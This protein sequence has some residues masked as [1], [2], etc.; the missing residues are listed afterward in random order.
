MN[1]KGRFQNLERSLVRF[2]DGKSTL[3]SQTFNLGRSR[4]AS[5]LVV[6]DNIIAALT[7]QSCLKRMHCASEHA[8]NG[9]EAIRLVQANHYDL[10]LMDLGLPDINGIETTKAIRALNMPQA[11]NVP[12]IAL[13][14]HSKDNEHAQLSLSAGM[15]AVFTKPLPQSTLKSILEHFVFKKRE[16]DFSQRDLQRPTKVIDWKASLQ[17]LNNDENLL[18][19]LLE[20]INIDL[21]NSLKT[22]EKAYLRGDLDALRVE[23]HRVRGGICYLCLPQLDEALTHFHK[24]VKTQPTDSELLAQS[25][26][27]V[28]AAMVAYWTSYNSKT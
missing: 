28:K 27:R 14:G 17:H 23:L 7:L 13:T 5:I 16:N 9:Q 12:I 6:E 11:L 19:E 4:A 18:Q 8:L 21:K 25:Y 15:Q 20:I 1:K 10:V 3:T 2:S 24:V 22:L 26:E